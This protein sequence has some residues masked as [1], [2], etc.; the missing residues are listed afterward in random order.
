MAGA[1]DA[2]ISVER[3]QLQ[4]QLVP[5]GAEIVVAGGISSQAGLASIRR[6]PFAALLQPER[7]T[8]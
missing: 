5:A 7:M 8:A 2:L 3:A 1:W 6:V 4:Q